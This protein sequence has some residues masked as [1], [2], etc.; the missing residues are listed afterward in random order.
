MAFFWTQ[1]E[2]EERMERIMVD[3]FTAM[4]DMAKRFN[5]SNRIAAYMLGVN[6]V[7]ETTRQRGI[8]A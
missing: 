4:V 3:S 7:A 8:Y 5:A 2:V 1:K 6:R